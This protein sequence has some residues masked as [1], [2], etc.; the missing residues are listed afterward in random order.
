MICRELLRILRRGGSFIGL[1]NLD[2]PASVCE[3]QSLSEE[4]I[5][6]HLLRHLRVQSYRIAPKGPDKDCYRYFFKPPPPR[7]ARPRILWVR[8]EKACVAPASRRC[9]CGLGKGSEHRPR[10]TR[11]VPRTRISC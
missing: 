9:D 7:R 8:A 5:D 11:N 6:R 4:L 3:P 1:F 10:E 2:E